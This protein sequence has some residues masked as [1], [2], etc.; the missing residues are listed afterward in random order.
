MFPT[1]L[2]DRLANTTDS[3]PTREST[4]VAANDA[5]LMLPAS[6]ADTDAISVF[7]AALTDA[8]S[9]FITALTDAS[10]NIANDRAAM[11]P[12]SDAF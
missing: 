8:I 11:E 6:T 12:T 10:F 1:D 9:V 3:E 5:V 7:I 4:D 2:T